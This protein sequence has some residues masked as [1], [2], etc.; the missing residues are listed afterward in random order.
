MNSTL[1]FQIGQQAPRYYESEVSL[2]MAPFV[3]SLV[4][5][6]VKKGDAVLDVAS[7]TGF[8]ARC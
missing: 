6:A 3:D 8:A 4:K 7:G 2:F 1:G 5:P